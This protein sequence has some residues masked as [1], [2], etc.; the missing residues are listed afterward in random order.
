LPGHEDIVVVRHLRRARDRVRHVRLDDGARHRLSHLLSEA[1]EHQEHRIRERFRPVVAAAL[2]EVGL[3]PSCVVEEIGRAKLIDEV[4]DRIAEHG[5]LNIGE[6]RDALSRNQMKLPDLRSPAELVLGDPLIRL[7]RKLAVVL[8]GVYRRGEF[9]MRLLHR[10]SSI[11]FGTGIGRLVL[12]LLI[13]PFGLAFFT[14]IT[15]GIAVEEG[16]KLI[17]WIGRMIGTIEPP[18]EG[19]APEPHAFP[20]P[21]LWGVAAL[22][23]FY[24]LLFNVASFRSGFF[25]GVRKT[26]HGVYSAHIWVIDHPAVQAFLHNPYWTPFRRLVVWPILSA[27]LGALVAWAFD[28]GTPSGVAIAS[29]GLTLTV[30]LL[31]TRLGRDIE[32]TFFDWLL[33]RWAWFSID[34]VP[35]LLHFIM[36]GF[37]W[38]LDA[39]EQML[40][41]VNEKLRFRSGENR[42]LIVI[43]AGLGLVNFFVTY[44]IRFAVNLLI[45]PQVNPIKHFPVV[46]VSHKI[47]LPMIPT[48]A[49]ILRNMGAQTPTTTA[50]G[51]VFGIPGI[52]GF[53]VWELKENW[54]LY[55]SNR[56]LVLKPIVIGSHG[57]TMRRLLHPGFHSGTIPKLYQKLRR[58]E[59]HG[60]R[61]AIRKAKGLLHHVEESIAHFIEREMLALLRR[62][63]AWNGLPIELGAVRLATNRV[64][65]ELRCPT[66]GD[67]PLIFAIDHHDGWLLAGVLERGWFV[68][69]NAGQQQ[70]LIC[71]LTGIYKLAGVDLTREQL[72]AKLP[73]DGFAYEINENKLMVRTSTEAENEID[74]TASEDLLL[75]N[76]PLP[77][78]D[79]VKIWEGSDV[80]GKG[81]IVGYRVI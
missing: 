16:E 51:I 24:V 25:L 58:A 11:A 37:R 30:I 65:V 49:D 27:A 31:N 75:S 72:A 8:D 46:T 44:V 78:S 59:R 17:G 56:P 53:M 48:L 57:E 14:M 50:T 43:K 34:F 35:G 76:I 23:V 71:A 81:G 15:P 28:L 7:N 47:C 45:E 12:L 21:N 29:G 62:S 42:I 69:L 79:W 19:A 32:E 61:S 13:L 38:A 77:W 26:A 52:F 9:Y 60:R 63:D 70:A 10:L 67:T 33:R 1:V 68:Q 20:T 40:Y 74:L 18:A 54:K 39:V 4:L 22:G 80:N 6:L 3:K 66:L 73:P 64:L 5:R 55:R 2:D 36:D 41:L